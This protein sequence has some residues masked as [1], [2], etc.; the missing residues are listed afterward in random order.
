[1]KM[2]SL[3]ISGIGG[4]ED[5]VLNFNSNMNIICGPNGIGKTTIL[6]CI[7]QSFT[8]NSLTYVRKKL[9]MKEGHGN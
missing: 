8:F 5:L 9:I 4:I 3:S 6:E 7:A 1:M 2:K